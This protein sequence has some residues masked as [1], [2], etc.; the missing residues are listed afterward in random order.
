MEAYTD[1][2][3]VYDIFMDETPYEQWADFLTGL[4]RQYG[5][6]KTTAEMGKAAETEETAKME[7]AVEMEEAAKME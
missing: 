7:E 4:I 1:F 3:D 6:S 2:A 5:V